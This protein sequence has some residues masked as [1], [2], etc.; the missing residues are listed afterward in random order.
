MIYSENGLPKRDMELSVKATL[1]MVFSQ[2]D[3]DNQ[4]M[5]GVLLKYHYLVLSFRRIPHILSQVAVPALKC[6]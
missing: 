5:Y 3:Y 1:V 4:N 6:A 2:E